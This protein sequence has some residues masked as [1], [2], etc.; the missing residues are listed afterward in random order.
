M[1]EKR[2]YCLWLDK[3]LKMQGRRHRIVVKGNKIEMSLKIPI[4]TDKGDRVVI[5]RQIQGRWRLIGYGIL[6]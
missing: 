3:T 6:S 2:G 4:C 5:S 1:I